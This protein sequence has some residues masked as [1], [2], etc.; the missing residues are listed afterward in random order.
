M[1]EWR[2]ISNVNLLANQCRSLKSML[3]VAIFR[4]LS[5]R[6]HMKYVPNALTIGRIVVTPI[7]LVLLF[8]ETL[9]GIAGALVLFIL[10]AVSDYLD[11]KIAR[12]YKVRSRFGQFLDPLADKVLVLGTFVVFAVLI[13]AIVPWWGVAIIALR[14]AVVTGLRSWAE[15]TGRSLRTLPIAKAK[16]AVQITFLIAMLIVLTG[17]KVQ[18]GTGEAAAWILQSWIPFAAFVIVVAF[19]VLTG[20]LYLLKQEFSS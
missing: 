20:L 6:L 11:G 10:A 7:M 1:L 5:A 17:E 4:S 14:D 3:T 12:D 9:F 18:G 2:A 8:S 15:S 19:T 16:T 13:P